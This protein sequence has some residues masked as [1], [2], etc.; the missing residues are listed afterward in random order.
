MADRFGIERVM[1]FSV[2][3]EAAEDFKTLAGLADTQLKLGGNLMKFMTSIRSA[4]RMSTSGVEARRH[5]WSEVK[6][7]RQSSANRQSSRTCWLCKYSPT[8]G[9]P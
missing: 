2:G 9:F 4:A 1:L 8:K 3:S 7:T 6:P 5:A